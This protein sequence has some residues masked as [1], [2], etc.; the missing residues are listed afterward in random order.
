MAAGLPALSF[1]A[2][3]CKVIELPAC[4]PLWSFFRNAIP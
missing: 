3:H 1:I 2:S 4:K